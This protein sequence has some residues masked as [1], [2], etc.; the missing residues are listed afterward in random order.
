MLVQKTRAL[1]E[2]NSLEAAIGDA[3][4]AIALDAARP[5]AYLAKGKEKII[6]KTNINA[7]D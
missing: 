3:T 1:T 2:I 7:I 6:S 4:S 5:E